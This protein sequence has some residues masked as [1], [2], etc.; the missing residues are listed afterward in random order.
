MLTVRFTVPAVPK[1]LVHRS[2]LLKRLTAGVEGPLTLVNGPA[3][4]GKTVLA[5]HWVAEGTAPGPTA[6]LTVE[7]GDAP[8][9]FWAY[10][11]EALDHSG[12]VLPAEVGRPTRAE[13][14][15][16]SF[17]V[18]LAEALAGSDRPAVLVL[19]QFDTAEA[20]DVTEGLDFVLRH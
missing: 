13:G 11:L 17:L 20:P 8:G 12:A 5:A 7:P 4:S 3:G 6:W 19:D 16:R 14:V 18:R 2:G 10:V 9:A 1:H 15:T